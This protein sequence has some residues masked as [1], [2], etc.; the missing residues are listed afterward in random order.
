MCKHSIEPLEGRI[1]LA[2]V[3]EGFV[4]AQVASNL[5][6]PTAMA[7]APDGRIFF[8]TQNGQIRIVKNGQLLPDPFA[9]VSANSEAERGLL[10]ITFDPN[11]ASNRNVYVYYTADGASIHNR[12]SRFTADGDVASGGE[13]IL[14]D[15]P[16][17]GDA[18]FHMG[19]ALNFGPDGK[20]YVA[21]GDHQDFS[22]PQFLGSVF[23]KM[24]R[25]NADGSIPDDNP[26][27]G[28]T[29]GINRAIW[30]RGLRN[31]FTFAFQPGSGRMFINDVGQEHWEEIDNGVAGANYGWPASEGPNNT[32][33]FSAPFYYYDH[34]QG[35]SIA[36]AAFYNP[37]AQ[38]FPA[39]F[40]GK[41]LFG[42]YCGEYIKT[43]DPTNASAV[44]TFATGIEGIV[45]IDVA[46][47]GSVYYLARGAT[48]N[49]GS[50]GRITYAQSGAPVI[51]THPQDR[52]AAIGESVT[53]SVV[54]SGNAPLSYQWQRNGLDITGANAS[55]YTVNSVATGDNGARFR[56][57]VSNAVG[58]V[59]SNE[60][61]LTVT[62]N[63]APTATITAPAAGTTFR[64]GDTIDYSGTGSDPEDGTLGA[65]AFTWQVDYYTNNL[66]RPFIPATS[67]ATSGSFVVPTT[68]VYKRPDVFYRI[69]L[70][71]RD[72][73]GR[74]HTTSRDIAPVTS[75]VTLATNIPGLRLTLDGQPMDAPFSFGSVVNFQRDIGAPSPQTVGNTSYEFVGWSDGGAVAHTIHTPDDDATYTATFRPVTLA[76]VS[77]LPFTS[78]TNGWGPVERDMS[79][80]E[81]GAGDGRPITLQGVVYNKGLGVHAQSDVRFDLGGNYTRFLADLGV[82][83]E[84]GDSGSV[85]FR[86]FT[87][88]GLIYDSGKRYGYS[89]TIS[90]DLDVTASQSLRLLVIDYGDGTNSDHADWAGARLVA[91]PTLGVTQSIFRYAT[92]P[93]ALTFRFDDDVSESLG[94][95]DLVVRNTTT[96]L[97]VPR[98]S[99]SLAYDDA[100]DTATVTFPGLPGGLLAEGAYRATI[101]AAG[102]VGASG[103]A[104]ANDHVLNFSF[105]TGDANGDGRVNLRDFNVLAANFG[106]V[107]RDFTQGDFNYDGIVNLRDFN[108]LAARFGTIL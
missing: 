85:G 9:T 65:A 97:D 93:H 58:S 2:D 92:A 72:A 96:G 38:Q 51:T 18:I 102:V 22:A 105:L 74:T 54:A 55:S 99:M 71:V 90:V 37:A 91:Q 52:S 40:A 8:T 98:D 69:I 6:S 63:Q 17:A 16:D 3:P 95:D 106:Q 33:G 42:D 49:S 68:G 45:D 4:D 60:G 101:L 5:F 80:G 36:G 70:T 26:F 86:V 107:N 35:C 48:L 19:G 79:N 12:V 66:A 44:T 87:D 94:L 82:D 108:L 67:G 77:D 46:P 21:V 39:S 11:F 1:L 14:L 76:Y 104:L 53:F 56:A 89:P 57:V 34:S 25:I 43:I 29:S 88:A 62:N 31:P 15:L 81:Q 10:G 103:G 75:T 83:D 61:V 32:G 7:L 30:A 28:Q 50:I 64:A 24:L 100:T 23:G 47:D 59:T 73:G 84:V 13:T 41:F 20:L 27:A 78:S